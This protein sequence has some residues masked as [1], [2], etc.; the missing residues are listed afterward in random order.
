[1][2]SHSKFSRS[3]DSALKESYFTYWTPDVFE[4]LILLFP[5]YLE[6]EVPLSTND[7]MRLTFSFN[8]L[9]GQ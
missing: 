7:D 3:E 9:Y 1:M 6:H 5:P 8:M 4:G 2:E